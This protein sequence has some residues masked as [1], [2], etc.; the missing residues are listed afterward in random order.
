[1]KTLGVYLTVKALMPMGMDD[2][3][4]GKLKKQDDDISLT[5]YL[6]NMES[7]LLALTLF[8]RDEMERVVTKLDA[9]VQTLTRKNIHQASSK[10]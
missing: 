8:Q 5:D 9:L 1:M 10:F 2:Y 4:Q 7:T 3:M 6:S